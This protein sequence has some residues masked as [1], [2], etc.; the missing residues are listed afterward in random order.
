MDFL[1]RNFHDIIRLYINQ[2]G[3]TIFA[4][5]LYTASGFP[6]DAVLVSKLRTAVSVF[7]LLFYFVLI[8]FVSWECGA[9]DKIRIDSGRVSAA[10]FK[11][12]IMSL[13]ANIP[14][15]LFGIV[16]LILAIVCISGGESVQGFFGIVFAIT[17][18]HASMYMGIIQTFVYGFN[19]PDPDVPDMN[20]YLIMAVLFTLL[21][22]I[23][24]AIN[25]LAYFLGSREIKLLSVFSKKNK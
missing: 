22:L 18:A 6:E 12:G 2:I 23:S 3:I 15:L 13:V 5:M 9:K 11:G 1:K 19:L 8:Y 20:K 14:N 21:P 4:L 10:P 25:Q 7:S 24:V 16:S 17:M